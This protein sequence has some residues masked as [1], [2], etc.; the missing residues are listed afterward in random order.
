MIEFS[1]YSVNC[2]K[3]NKLFD[4]ADS[5][6][7][8]EEKRKIVLWFFRCTYGIMSALLGKT[9]MNRGEFYERFGK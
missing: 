4:L 1:I 6:D 9:V 2:E 3:R 7:F 8:I 5:M